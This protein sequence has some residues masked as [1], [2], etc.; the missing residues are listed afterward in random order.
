LTLVIRRLIRRWSRQT[1]LRTLEST[2]PKK[3]RPALLLGTLDEDNPEASAGF[4]R[5][6]SGQFTGIVEH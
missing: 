6:A 5:D 1:A 4:V 3:T 2:I